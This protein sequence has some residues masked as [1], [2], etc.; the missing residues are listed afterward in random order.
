[1]RAASI[2]VMLV[3]LFFGRS[4]LG[5]FTSRMLSPQFASPAAP[6]IPAD[7]PNDV[8][9][10]PNFELEDVEN[11]AGAHVL[12]MTAKSDA[13]S[14]LVYYQQQL[15][16][17]GWKVSP[18]THEETD[19]GDGIAITAEKDGRQV[20]VVITPWKDGHSV[21]QQMVR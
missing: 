2:G 15:E 20:A 11:I 8:P 12:D 6:K 18:A 21:V 5:F 17:Y 3:A 19:D 4:Y 7:F 9:V 10:F 13:Q 14:V 16:G 1:M